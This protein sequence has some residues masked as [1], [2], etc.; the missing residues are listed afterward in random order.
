M[1]SL[2][3][4]DKVKVSQWV[5]NRIEYGVLHI[6]ELYMDPCA[7]ILDPCRYTDVAQDSELLDELQNL[8]C[9]KSFVFL[10]C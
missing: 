1:E 9:K 4:N 5:Q 7:M 3:L 6:H 8:Y 10:G 2:D